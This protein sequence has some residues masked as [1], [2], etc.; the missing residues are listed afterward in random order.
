ME[1]NSRDFLPRIKTINS[2]A[3]H[4]CDLLR[5]RSHASLS[6]DDPSSSRVIKEVLYPKFISPENY[7]RSR[8]AAP[9]SS[10]PLSPHSSEEENGRFGGLF[11][12]TFTHP[13]AAQAF[14]DTLACAKGPSLG[15][16]FTLAC[17]YV[18]LA[19]YAEMDWAETFGVERTLVRVS[20][21]ME[22][23]GVL[24]R[25]FGEAVDAAERAVR[26]AKE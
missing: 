21:G 8:R 10:S 20:V 15:T 14:F 11:S 13:A 19:H 6:S 25:W 2:N 22:E 24:T 16:N 7:L 17:P 3:E 5:T 12:L 4:L 26:V 18:V 23:Q 1:R 9:P